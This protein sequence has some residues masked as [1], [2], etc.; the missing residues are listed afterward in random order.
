MTPATIHRLGTI[1]RAALRQPTPEA[2][3]VRRL[4]L[5]IFEQYRRLKNENKTN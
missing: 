2:L 1:Y 5:A 4:V 3:Q